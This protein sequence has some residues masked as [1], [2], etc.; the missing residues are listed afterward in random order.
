MAARLEDLRI[1]RSQ[2]Q[3]E[4]GPRRSLFRSAVIGAVVLIA[5]GGAL[6]AVLKVRDD[7][8][9]TVHVMQV[10]PALTGTGSSPVQLHANGY[11]V[12]EHEIEVASKIAGRVQWIGVEKGDRVRRG[13]ILVRLDD[14]EAR[15]QLQQAQANLVAAEA[16]LAELKAGSRPQE[17]GE[18]R[19]AFQ[20][21]QADASNQDIALR[22]TTELYRSGIASRAQYDDAVNQA[23][24]AHARLDS[25]RQNLSMVEIGPR[26]EEITLARAQ[27]D[28]ARA[29]VTYQQSL[30]DATVIRAPISGT[31]LERDIE[32]GEMISTMNFGGSS[33]IK[34]SAVTLADLRNVDVQLDISEN[35]IPGVRLHQPALIRLNADSGHTYHGWVREIAPEADR[36]K[37]TVQVKVRIADPDAALRPE[38][39][40]GVDLLRGRTASAPSTPVLLIPA[41]AV[42]DHSVFVVENGTAFRRTVE[43]AAAPD[44][45]FRVLSGVR[46]GDELVLDPPATLKNRQRVRAAIGDAQ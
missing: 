10:R 16:K 15:A 4:P 31:V 5:A 13:Q 27:V 25:A 44:D 21:A 39:D 17:V 33:G 6:F 7:T 40:T 2:R 18:A 3:D 22:R 12:P 36:A 11:I 35:Q 28:Q 23:K 30:L 14:T 20:Q 37:A 32:R 29:A 38:M 34:P 43:T 9:P 26:T 24:M 19:A 45:Q 41:S 1:D 42:R 8:T 46:P